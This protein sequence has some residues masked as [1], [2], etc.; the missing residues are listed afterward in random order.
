MGLSE[1]W[2]FLSG[3]LYLQDANLRFSMGHYDVS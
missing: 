1:V 2:F 3:Y